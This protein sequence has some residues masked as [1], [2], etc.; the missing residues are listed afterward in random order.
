MTQPAIVKG[1][2]MSQSVPFMQ[3]RESAKSDQSLRC[4]HKVSEAMNYSMSAR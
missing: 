4:K 3:A 2:N 1:R